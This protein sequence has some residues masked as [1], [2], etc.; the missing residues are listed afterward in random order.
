MEGP[1]LAFLDNGAY[2]QYQACER[3]KRDVNRK[4][5]RQH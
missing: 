4:Q 5:K 3:A 2:N 1:S